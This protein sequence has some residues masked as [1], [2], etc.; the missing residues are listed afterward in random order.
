MTTYPARA[1]YKDAYA[2]DRTLA[3]E[4]VALLQSGI[5]SSD[6]TGQGRAATYAY[7]DALGRTTTFLNKLSSYTGQRRTSEPRASTLP[8]SRDRRLPVCSRAILPEPYAQEASPDR[9][10]NGAG[11]V[12]IKPRPRK[13]GHV[14]RP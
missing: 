2:A 9:G 8:G 11:Y 12:G 4:W 14:T 6:L 1:R 3:K 7:D 10:R 5:Y 13:I